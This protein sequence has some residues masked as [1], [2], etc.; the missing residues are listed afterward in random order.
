[1]NLHWKGAGGKS[2][3]TDRDDANRHCEE[4]SDEAIS[5]G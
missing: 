3:N 1:M 4:R 5:M 2:E